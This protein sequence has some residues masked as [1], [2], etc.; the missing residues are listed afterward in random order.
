MRAMRAIT[1]ALVLLAG[2]AGQPEPDTTAAAPPPE[3]TD[4]RDLSYLG[5][6]TPG[7]H[8]HNYW[9]GSDRLVVLDAEGGPRTYQADG[10]AQA[11]SFQPP[12]GS[13]VPQ[14]A[15]L[16]EITADWTLSQEGL[17]LAFASDFDR[18]EVWV[19]TAA[20]GEPQ[21][22]G[23]IEKGGTLLL[24][25]TNEQADPPHYV[26]SLWRFDLLVVKDG[27]GMTTFSGNAHMTVTA[28]RTLPLPVF[29]PHPD[30]WNGAMELPL[31]A[32]DH[33]VRQQVSTPYAV[34]CQG[35]LPWFSP[36]V[37]LVVPHDATEVVI[38]VTPGGGSTPVP[39]GLRF[40]G[41]DTYTWTE[42]VPD[43]TMPGPQVYRIAVTGSGDS[44][45]A[46]Q[47]LWEFWIHLATPEE[48]GAW[49]GTLQVR[50]IAVR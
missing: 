22:I 18:A 14:G 15:G 3:V 11:G 40:H 49:H 23:P 50:A 39:L 46:R 7:E 43:T 21:R 13:I 4:P 42:A 30:R 6:G 27:G 19:K 20:D 5:D 12:E 26:L 45:Y 9:G 35:C 32:F 29:P 16:I 44:P 41:A 1:L 10:S 47:S 8:V 36:D 34:Q 25:S 31:A 33:E 38:E 24:N 37:D 28:Y 48:S 2:C 17:S